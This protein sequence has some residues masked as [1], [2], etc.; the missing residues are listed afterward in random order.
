MKVLGDDNLDGCW[1]DLLA[2]EFP[3]DNWYKPVEEEDSPILK[4]N[5]PCPAIELSDDEIISWSKPWK[6]TLIVKV[7]GTKVSFRML[8]N[9][10]RRS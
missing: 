1:G 2:E 10:L 5:C 6:N 3:E 8:E 9:K 4:S 7:L